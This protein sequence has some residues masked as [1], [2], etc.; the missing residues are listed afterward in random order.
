MADKKMIDETASAINRAA[1]ELGRVAQAVEDF[2]DTFGGCVQKIEREETDENGNEVIRLTPALIVSNGN[3][4]DALAGACDRV[5]GR[6]RG[7]GNYDHPPVMSV[8]ADSEYMTLEEL[9]HSWKNYDEEGR[10][11]AFL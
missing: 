11:H 2:I 5:C 10:K 9:I 3:D 6:L 1:F 7:A 8:P 4:K